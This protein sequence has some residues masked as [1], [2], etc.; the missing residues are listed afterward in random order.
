MPPLVCICYL[1]VGNDHNRA[2]EM[3]RSDS[4]EKKAL[5]SMIPESSLDSPGVDDRESQN[6]AQI[7]VF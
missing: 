5:G 3:K 4:S 1:N 7:Y 6:M 2:V